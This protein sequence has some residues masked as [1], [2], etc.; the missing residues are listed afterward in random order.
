MTV[1]TVHLLE[2]ELRGLESEMKI[3]PISFCG[4]IRCTFERRWDEQGLSSQEIFRK[5]ACEHSSARNVPQAPHVQIVQGEPVVVRHKP[6][7]PWL[8]PL[9]EEQILAD[10]TIMVHIPETYDTYK[11]NDC[12]V[13]LSGYKTDTGYKVGSGYKPESVNVQTHIWKGAAGCRYIKA[14]YRG[15]EN[16]LIALHGQVRCKEGCVALPQYILCADQGYVTI[17]GRKL[18]VICCAIEGDEHQ[19]NCDSIAHKMLLQC[20]ELAIDTPNTKAPVFREPQDGE[21]KPT[22]ESQVWMRTEFNADPANMRY[23]PGTTDTHQCSACGISVKDFVENDTL[24]G[25]H[26]YHVYSEGACCPY[27]EERFLRK[28]DNLRLILGYERYRRGMFAFP[29][30]AAKNCYGY[31]EINGR[32]RCVVCAASREYGAYTTEHHRIMCND[33]KEYMVMKLRFFQMNT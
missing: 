32:Y 25:D 16:H 20:K 12:G 31:V 23:V 9:T 18:C 24:L 27:I 3:S 7:R 21:S 22:A 4:P 26:I 2:R 8:R 10:C 11:C 5:R 19:R 17:A 33:I 6:E 29:D 30:A 15:R 1:S 28:R 14:K 13:I